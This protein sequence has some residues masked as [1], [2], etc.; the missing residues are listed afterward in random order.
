[1]NKL[2]SLTV[3]L[4]S[5]AFTTSQQQQTEIT[6]EIVNIKKPETFKGFTI[7]DKDYT[8][9]FEIEKNNPDSYRDQKH[10][11]VISI[12]L[13]NDSHYISPFA[14]RDFK[15]K[16]YVDLGSYNDLDFEGDIIESPRSVEEYDSHPFV[17]GTVNWVRTNTTYKQPLQIKTQKEFVVFGRVQFTIEPR[18][19][20]EEIPFAI[21]YQN[22]EMVFI[23]PKC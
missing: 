6:Q 9:H 20:F 5:F 22:G 17:N 7:N 8:L 16:F 3:V 15:G 4:L 19:T 13:H 2:T 21:S 14:K 18:C 12:E 10:T 1:M 23:E 11:L